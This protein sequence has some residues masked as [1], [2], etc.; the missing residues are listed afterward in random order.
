M[1]LNCGEFYDPEMVI[2]FSG[3][4]GDPYQFIFKHTTLSHGSNGV[5]VP[6]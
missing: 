6:P 1:T 5:I 2:T 4:N 3:P